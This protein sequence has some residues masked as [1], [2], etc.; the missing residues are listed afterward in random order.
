MRRRRCHKHPE[1]F[2]DEQG[3]LKCS[4]E[5]LTQQNATLRQVMEQF[6]GS[7]VGL[8]VGYPANHVLEPLLD[9]FAWSRDSYGPDRPKETARICCPV[10]S[11]DTG[12]NYYVMQSGLVAVLTAVWAKVG[13]QIV[14]TAEH[15]INNALR[16]Q[17]HKLEEFLVAKVLPESA[18]ALAEKEAR[19]SLD[20]YLSKE[21]KEG[22]NE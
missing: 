6:A 18:Y 19:K 13:E 1:Q 8:Y 4:I 2:C 21:A 12:R 7:P 14:E 20:R 11:G 10:N 5:T 22:K 16:A 3:C 9:R 17:R 15:T